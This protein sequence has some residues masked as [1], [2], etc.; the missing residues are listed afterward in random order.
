MN[1]EIDNNMVL[2]IKDIMAILQ[3]GRATV[4]KLIQSGEL[5][6]AKIAGK[7]RTTKTAVYK[8]LNQAMKSTHFI[9]QPASSYN[10][11]DCFNGTR[12][13]PSAERNRV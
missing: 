2:T 10:R 1:N 13:I 7:Y 6:A 5:K 12:E 11:D 9:M 8:Y 3:I 4:Y